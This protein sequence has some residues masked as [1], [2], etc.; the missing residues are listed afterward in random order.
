MIATDRHE[1]VTDPE[2]FLS[3]KKDW[4]ALYDRCAERDLTL[5]FEWCRRSWELV[6]KPQGRRLHCLVVW[7]SDQAVLIWPFA[8]HGR[9]LRTL[10][11]PLGPETSEY[12]D[13]LVED[14]CQADQRVAYA[15]NMLRKDLRTGKILLP[16]VKSGSR[17]YRAVVTSKVVPRSVETWETPQVEWDMYPAWNSYLNHLGRDFRAE[18]RRTRRRLS[19]LGNLNFE[20]TTDIR[21]F[22]T[23]LE[24]IFARKTDWLART[25]QK[26]IWRKADLYRDFLVAM[27]NAELNAQLRLFS[28][29]LNDQ[30]ISAVVC[31]KSPSRLENVLAAFDQVY[32]KFGPGQLLYEDVLNWAF[33]H[34]LTCDFRLGAQAYKQSWATSVS[35]VT[36]YEFVNQLRNSAM[37]VAK[38]AYEATRKR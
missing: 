13:V 8:I 37:I 22:V 24:W 15:W 17:L 2:T 36:T 25:H 32:G 14:D 23:T 1:I 38:F 33:E 34:R 5:S 27:A 12:S 30:V 10:A 20:P 9:F 28:L 18:L 11:R 3:L 4:N 6:A 31:R 16:F 29:K 26:S 19:E 35:Q 21:N 7:R